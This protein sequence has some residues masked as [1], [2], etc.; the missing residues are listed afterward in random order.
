MLFSL[1]NHKLSKFLPSQ[2]CLLFGL[3][4]GMFKA[5]ARPKVLSIDTLMLEGIFLPLEELIWTPVY[6]NVKIAGNGNMLPYRVG[7]KEQNMLSTTACINLKTTTNLVS[8]TKQITRSIHHALKL[9]K[10]NHAH[11]FLS[12]QI[13]KVTIRWT[14]TYICS[15]NIGSTRNSITKILSRSVKTGPSQFTQL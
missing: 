9:K 1:Q 2:I 7:F 5:E 3:T 4:F 13:A 15:G 10:V 8:A 11:T 14:L 6:L 12:I